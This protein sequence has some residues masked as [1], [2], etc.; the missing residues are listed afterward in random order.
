MQRA[1]SRKASRRSGL[2]LAV[3]MAV[4]ATVA[5][6]AIAFFQSQTTNQR[7]AENVHASDLAREAAEAGIAAGLDA[8]QTPEWS[9]VGVPISAEVVRDLRGAS[10]YRVGFQQVT[11][12]EISAGAA[13]AALRV[14]IRSV[15]SWLASGSARPVERAI[16]ATVV[17]EPRLEGRPARPGDDASAE[18]H[19]T[20]ASG[21]EQARHFAV[22]AP[23]GGD[24]FELTP[25]ARVSGDTWLGRRL[26]LYNNL[27]WSSDARAALLSG[28]GTDNGG[29]ANATL[30]HPL[31]GS[32]TFYEAPDSGQLDDL[33]N[34]LKTPVMTTATPRSLP[35]FDPTRFLNYRLFDGGFEYHAVQIGSTLTSAQNNSLHPTESNPLGI[36]YCNGS[37]T[38]GDEVIVN[39]TL[40]ATSG[41]AFTGRGIAMTPFDWRDGSGGSLVTDRDLWPILPAVVSGSDIACRSS[42]QVFIEGAVV[43]AGDVVVE[44]PD[45]IE[46][47]ALLN[48]DGNAVATPLGHGLSKVNVTDLLT[49]LSGLTVN[50]QHAV[51]FLNGSD[52]SEWYP[53][54]TANLLTGE[55]AVR[56]TVDFP[57][58]T[59]CRFRPRRVHHTDI[60][61][62]VIARRVRFIN[63]PAWS[64][65]SSGDWTTKYNDWQTKRNGILG[66]VSARPDLT[67]TQSLQEDGFP[68]AP[69]VRIAR[70]Q[71]VN[72]VCEP[73]LFSADPS[74]RTTGGGYRWRVVSWA[75]VSL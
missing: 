13:H 75:E 66:V 41:V 29:G 61:G 15:G 7:A 58:P 71:N 12:D 48:Y 43:A 21:F 37:V 4:V 31:A 26:L 72:Y 22:F 23:E 9:G 30:P 38:V 17:L 55:F 52:L 56:G 14:Q 11:D 74:S 36:F 42:A 57:S 5:I 65:V 3:V 73:P 53:I 64:A 63:P 40:V 60:F 67:F 25:E 51:Q 47:P 46:E 54:V 45:F 49:L 70:P 19:R 1:F 2:T 34:R 27:S 20:D 68:F 6:V 50:T 8:I 69:T 44:T 10:A 18:D 32:I 59:A 24:S 33:T 28:L 39:G 35:T 62:P 16:E